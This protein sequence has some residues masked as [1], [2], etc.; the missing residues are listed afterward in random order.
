MYSMNH[1]NDESPV[2]LPNGI[3]LRFFR[4][5]LNH[6]HVSG[7]KLHKLKPALN[8]AT[9]HGYETLI[10]FG[11]PYSNHL[12][13]LAWV[14][15]ERGLN[16]IGLVRGELHSE[17]TPTLKD[18]QQWGMQLVPVMRKDYRRLI[19]KL[20]VEQPASAVGELLDGVLASFSAPQ[21]TLIIPEGGSTATA[22]HALSE[23]YKPIFKQPRFVDTTHAFCATGTGATV[24]GLYKASPKHVSVFGVQAV[25]EGDA[26]INRINT[27]LENKALGL[28]IVAGHLGGFANMPRELTEF[29]SRFE[30]EHQV[31]LDAVYNGKVVYQIYKM[32]E[33]GYFPLTSKVLVV[34][35]GGLQ[36]KRTSSQT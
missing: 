35:T 24:A 12:H 26:T 7:N 29:I 9:T 16:S 10:S 1:R 32:A 31:P 8:A 11:G 25:A 19:N 28:T 34:H 23:A 20:Q 36:G 18:C 6:P 33:K 21:N 15:K 2:I 3:E 17:L 13:A 5:D 30:H 22:V 14:C 27:W 4:D